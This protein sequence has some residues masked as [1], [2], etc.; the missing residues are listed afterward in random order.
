M[1]TKWTYV[2]LFLITMVSAIFFYQK[3]RKAP[4]IKFDQL[5][6]SDLEAKP[7]SFES[8]FGKKTIVSFGASWCGNCI[9]E[10]NALKELQENEL[11]DVQVIVISDESTERI[12]RF[13]DSLEYPFIFLRSDQSF[14][15]LG[16]NSLPTSYLLNKNLQVKE[17]KMGEMNWSDA[18]N[19]AH[20][21]KLME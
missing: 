10:L 15:G 14:S 3:Y 16:I 8:L 11:K 17:E 7:F 2:F 20:F 12:I 1:N 9:D 18:S 4:A 5:Q 13:R 21:L 19:R 6:L